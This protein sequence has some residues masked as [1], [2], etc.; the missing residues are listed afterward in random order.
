M[1][2]RGSWRAPAGDAP[3]RWT[4]GRRGTPAVI[5]PSWNSRRPA[6]GTGEETAAITLAHGGRLFRNLALDDLRERLIEG[7]PDT[8]TPAGVLPGN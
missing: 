8:A 5:R 4:A 7:P 3:T 6:R 2:S 1:A